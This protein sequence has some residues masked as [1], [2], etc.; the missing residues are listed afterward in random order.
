MPTTKPEESA[1]DAARDAVL[2]KKL[3]A[4]LKSD[5]LYKK[6]GGLS[7]MNGGSTQKHHPNECSWSL[8]SKRI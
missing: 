7:K 5:N 6:V 2:L 3:Q 1:R 8:G 4:Y